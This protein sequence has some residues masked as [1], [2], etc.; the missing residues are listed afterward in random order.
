[1]VT[2]LREQWCA[3]YSSGMQCRM[4]AF[5]VSI[6]YYSSRGVRLRKPFVQAVKCSR[7]SSAPEAVP[8]LSP[9]HLQL[10]QWIHI[11]KMRANAWIQ[12]A[13]WFLWIVQHTAY[14][15]QYTAYSIQHTAYSIQHSMGYP[16]HSYSCKRYLSIRHTVY[17][18]NCTAYGIQYTAYSI[19]SIPVQDYAL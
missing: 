14:S 9:I 18:L 16:Y 11:P 15:I 17:N 7:D 8:Y 2:R 12:E 6:L 13:A 10:F 4:V 1:M 5:L 19:Y 3:Q